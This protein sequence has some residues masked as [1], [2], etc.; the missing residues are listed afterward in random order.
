MGVTSALA[1]WAA[2][3]A[4]FVGID[5][6]SWAYWQQPANAKALSESLWFDITSMMNFGI[7]LGALLAASLAG[8]FART[9][10]FQNVH[11]LLRL[12]AV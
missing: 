1:V 9:S 12:L 7:M 4:S 3:S 6:A 10:I 5:V 8:K 2:K 11:W